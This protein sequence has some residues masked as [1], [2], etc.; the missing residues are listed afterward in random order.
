[1]RESAL[2]LLFDVLTAPLDALNWLT[3]QLFLLLNELFERFGTP[4]VFVAALAEATVG[5]GVVFPGVVLLF[6]GGAFARGDGS[7][8]ALVLALGV[9]GT[10]LGDTISYTLGRF[11]SGWVEQSRFGAAV[12]MGATLMSG[13]TRW[14]IPFYHLHSA[15]RAVGPFSAGVIRLPLRMWMPLDYAGA[16]IAN[17]I[18]IGAGALLGRAVLTDDGR[19]EQHPALRI[20][21]A[22]GATVWLLL[23]RRVLQRKLE[24]VREPERPTRP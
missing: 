14:F 13:R 2:D 24:Q 20:G 18:W 5:V 7:E 4:I 10:I 17:S 11:G 8:L 16:L 23:M 19:L 9:A 12:R 1:V 3:D 21:L 6:L 22:V 15:T